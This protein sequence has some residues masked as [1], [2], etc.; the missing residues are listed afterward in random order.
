MKNM[1]KTL[2]LIPIFFAI[3]LFL[4]FSVSA[5][6]DSMSDPIVIDFGTTYSG[7]FSTQDETDYYV[8]TLSSSGRVTFETSNMSGQQV[9]EMYDENGAWYFF[10]FKDDR[11]AG[12]TL[13]NPGAYY[14]THYVE[15]YLELKAGTY[16]FQISS[17]NL[18]YG[19]YSFVLQFDSAN[20]SFR[21][22]CQEENDAFETASPISFDKIYYGQIAEFDFDYYKFELP[23]SDRLTRVTIDL[24]PASDEIE[25]VVW[26]EYGNLWI[27]PATDA[28][29]S[30][31]FYK[32][33]YVVSDIGGERKISVEL[34]S[35]IHYL[36]FFGVNF[37][38]YSFKIA[39]EHNCSGEW[40]TTKESTCT[41]IGIRE[42]HCEICGAILD[43][44][45]IPLSE[46]TF[47]DWVTEKEA[48]CSSEGIRRSTCMVCGESVTE[49]IDAFTHNYGEWEVVSGSKLIPPILK[50]RRCS[51]CGDIVA[52]E[53]WSYVWV[54]IV[55]VFVAIGVIIGVINYIRAFKKH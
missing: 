14:G 22:T 11:S 31:S 29:Y 4:T 25:M 18:P 49:T 8:F 38:N 27:D 51:L 48:T 33:E 6:G 26:D 13:F 28:S 9:F 21:E 36:S 45:M 19:T 35:G 17:G 44:E 47:S 46:H 3:A 12:T 2:L 40:I 55:A 34:H 50:E 41:D 39:L 37:G 20:E 52:T 24:T 32:Q 30:E 43:E 53:D 16:R 1:K 23:S 54:P 5:A 10:H 42:K 15:N 7:E